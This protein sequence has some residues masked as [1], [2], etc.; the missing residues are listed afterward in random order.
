MSS[1]ASGVNCKPTLYR[2]RLGKGWDRKSGHFGTRH[3]RLLP[4]SC[5]NWRAGAAYGYHDRVI[6]RRLLTIASAASLILSIAVIVLWVR[7]YST[8]D[9]VSWGFASAPTSPEKDVAHELYL[10]SYNGRFGIAI[11]HAPESEKES[12]AVGVECRSI[13]IPP[14]DPIIFNHFHYSGDHRYINNRGHRSGHGHGV[15]VPHP[16]V[17]ALFLATPLLFIIS[18]IRQRGRRMPGN[19]HT[20]GYN[21]TGNTSGVCPECG[22]PVPSK[23]EAIA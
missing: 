20:C 1:D 7:S 8:S 21:L 18:H 9:E 10:G 19:C 5:R 15:D 11:C 16:A 4:A 23:P 14:D 13:T 2:S 3:P 6:R 22:T 12:L 17:V